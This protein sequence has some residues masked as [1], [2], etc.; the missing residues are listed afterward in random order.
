MFSGK[1]NKKYYENYLEKEIETLRRK[2]K[3]LELERDNAIREKNRSDEILHKYK[4]DYELL[5]ADSKKL[6]EKQK[7]AN[8][9]M[10]KII[11]NCRNELG[12]LD[13]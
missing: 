8:K 12:R 5:I 9:T 6:L 7:N 11:T 2:N 4:T 10:D 13:K 1:A 3:Q